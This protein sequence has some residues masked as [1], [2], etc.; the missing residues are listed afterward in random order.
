MQILERPKHQPHCWLILTQF[1]PIEG[2]TSV[3]KQRVTPRDTVGN[4]EFLPAFG[5]V[6]IGNAELHEKV[7]LRVLR[8][9]LC[10]ALSAL[11]VFG[12]RSSNPELHSSWRTLPYEQQLGALQGN[13]RSTGYPEAPATINTGLV[14]S[15]TRR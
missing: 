4:V 8:Q 10:L 2:L 11:H 1:S 7:E 3:G 15:S 5:F 12:C 14:R 13:A 6:P 9:Y